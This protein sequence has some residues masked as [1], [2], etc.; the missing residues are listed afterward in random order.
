MIEFKDKQLVKAISDSLDLFTGADGGGNFIKF[1]NFL[2]KLE[3]EDSEDSRQVLEVVKRFGKLIYL[4][5]NK[6]PI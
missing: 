6:F 2:N 5:N 4:I 3:E 1:C